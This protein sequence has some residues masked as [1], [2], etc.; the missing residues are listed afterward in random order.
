[1][2]SCILRYFIVIIIIIIFNII[3]V[4]NAEKK[5]LDVGSNTFH[6]IVKHEIV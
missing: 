3:H 6:R 4:F 1:M 2:E 5:D